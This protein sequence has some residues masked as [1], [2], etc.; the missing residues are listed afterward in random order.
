MILLFYGDSLVNG[1]GDPS[2]LGWAGR[3]GI[4]AWRKGARITFYNLGVRKETSREVLARWESEF[5]PRRL[6]GLE[7][8]LIFSYGT[9]DS[10]EMN[11]ARRVSLEETASNT[12][13][14]LETAG[15]YGRVLF[16]GPPPVLDSAHT[17]RNREASGKIAEVC[18]GFGAPFLDPLPDLLSSEAYM[19]DLEAGDGI[20]PGPDGY[21]VLAGMVNNWEAWRGLFA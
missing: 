16:V 13:A 6:E 21:F 18:A 14:I 19:R 12:G 5:E 4:D 2:C 7:A 9:G 3:C 10:A 20:H 8:V 1:T 11:G 15:M 17:Q